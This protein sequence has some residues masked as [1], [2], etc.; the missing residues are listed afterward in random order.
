MSPTLPAA[1]RR[2]AAL[3]TAGIAL[4]TIADRWLALRR[5]DAPPP[6]LDMLAVVDAPIER[7][8]AVVADVPRQPE[9]MH[10]MKSV[11]L[12][13][14]GRVEPGAR[15]EATVRILGIAVRDPVVIAAVEPPRRFAVRHEG[16]FAGGGIIT[17]EP[18]V[19]GSTTIVRWA[20]T[21]VPPLLPDLLARLQAPILRRIFQDDLLRLKALVEAESRPRPA[22]G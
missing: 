11:R 8:W 6:A 5:G 15:G 21:L 9:W 20:E 12:E 2:A 14:P 1:L 13:P 22:G 3:A 19:D 17:L 16:R 7:T 10:E 18:G 4:A